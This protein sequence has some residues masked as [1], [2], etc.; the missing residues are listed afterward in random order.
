M[1]ETN[2]TYIGK[3]GYTIY[4]DCL[5]PKDLKFIRDSLNVAPYIPKSPVQPEAF[6]VFLES[7][8]KI[9]MPRYFGLEHF[10]PPDEYK[11]SHGE[12]I[13]IEFNGKVRDNQK[14]IIDTYMTK[15]D[16]E[17]GGGGLLDVPC[18]WGKT[19]MA[20]NIISRL[21]TKTLVIVHKGFLLN[22]WIE[23]ITEFL[24]TAKVG[25]IQGKIIDIEGKDIV[26]G[27]LQSLSMKTYSDDMFTCFGL[28]IVDECHHISSEVFSKSLS[29]IV[30]KYT[31]GLSATMNR[32]DGLTHVFK[33]FLGEIAFSIEREKE[34]NVLVKA[35][36][37]K[38]NDAEFE[39]V[40][41]DYR[42]NPQYSTMITK[43]CDYSD[44]SE[45]ILKVVQKELAETPNQ[46]IMILG[47]NKSILVYIHDAIE[48]RK[49][50]SVGYYVGGM[51][52]EKLK[53]SE[54]K[55]I[56]VA[57]Y[58]M[59]AEGLDIKSLTTL[60][61][62]T[63]RTD[64]VQAVGRILRVKRDRPLVIDIVDT[65]EVFKRQYKKRLAFYRKNNYTI[66]ESDS[67]NYFKDIWKT[68]QSHTTSQK[69]SKCLISV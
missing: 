37:F 53:E 5:T 59:A 50:A 61:L 4:K 1:S 31:L 58:A 28:T 34:D 64:V 16:G 6:P 32:K 56:I 46:Q 2:G 21:N 7:R 60:I 10:G 19:A 25:R 29:S 23:R 40:V 63:P 55:T 9:Y 66:T 47:Q 39:E 35:L 67:V 12:H 65:H 22:Q 33:M 27:M 41:L 20:L 13:K 54:T 43:I 38:S 14:Q 8:N 52:E 3:R 69:V 44:R 57:T 11:L 36:E 24:P 15:I 48:H 51:K 26:I 18:G 68:K 17:I 62:A 45:F 42:G 30:T 49:I